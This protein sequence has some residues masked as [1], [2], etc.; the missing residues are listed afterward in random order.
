MHVLCRLGY[1]FWSDVNHKV[2]VRAQLNGTDRKV[3]V[4]SGLNV[5]GNVC[6]SAVFYKL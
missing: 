2:I 6:A 1:M 5:S 4:Q 3:L